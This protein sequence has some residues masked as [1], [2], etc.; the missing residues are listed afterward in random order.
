[1]PLTAASTPHSDT[2]IHGLTRYPPG[3]MCLRLAERVT[4]FDCEVLRCEAARR[5]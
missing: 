4:G 3:R 1:M 5:A 2:H